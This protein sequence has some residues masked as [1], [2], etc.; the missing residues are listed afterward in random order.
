MVELSWLPRICFQRRVEWDTWHIFLET[1]NSS[2]LINLLSIVL[3]IPIQEEKKM[4]TE[5]PQIPHSAKYNMDVYE[6]Q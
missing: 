5:S 6:L 1:Y 3:E 2:N 4:N